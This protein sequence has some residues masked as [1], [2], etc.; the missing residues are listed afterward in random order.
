M[1]AWLVC[2]GRAE[3]VH[4]KTATTA[5]AGQWLIPRPIARLQRFSDDIELLSVNFF[6]HWP[7]GEPLFDL[8]DAVILEARDH[9]KMEQRAMALDELIGSLV[10]S[11]GYGVY[12]REMPVESYLQIQQVFMDFFRVLIEALATVGL[13]PAPP[14]S[15]DARL[16]LALNLIER[17]PYNQPIP[18]PQLAQAAGLSVVHLN[19][20]AVQHLGKTLRQFCDRRRGEYARR[21]LLLPGIQVKQVALNLGFSTAGHFS[22]W[23]SKQ[24]GL[25]PRQ[26]QSQPRLV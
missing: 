17:H 4:G 11:H 23:F 18:L 1:T 25:S 3:V 13:T 9:P 14:G 8:S 24:Y 12:M 19:R 6:A 22:R 7:T 15:T 26:F 20:L 16:S 2:R 21:C 5:N 10:A